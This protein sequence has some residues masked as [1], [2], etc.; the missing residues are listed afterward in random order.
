MS[1]AWDLHTPVDVE[2]LVATLALQLLGAGGCL[3]IPQAG[4]TQRLQMLAHDLDALIVR[5][6]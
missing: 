4:M 2:I 3:R 5:R 1:G 6:E